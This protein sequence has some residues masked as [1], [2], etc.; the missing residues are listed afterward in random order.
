MLCTPVCVNLIL[1]SGTIC[2]HCQ[3]S[4]CSARCTGSMITMRKPTKTSS[5]RQNRPSNR[6]IGRLSRLE[7]KQRPGVE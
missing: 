2:E 4:T 3:C 5:V 1:G 6:A 7:Q